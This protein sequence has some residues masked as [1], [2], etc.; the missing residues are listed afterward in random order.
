MS[1]TIESLTEKQKE[2]LKKNDI[3]YSDPLSEYERIFISLFF[4]GSGT[5]EAIKKHMKQFYL[6]EE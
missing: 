5:K 6:S 3:Q 4:T 1:F 2:R